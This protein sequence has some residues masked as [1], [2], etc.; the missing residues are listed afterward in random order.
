MPAYD[1]A[2]A[3]AED[4]SAQRLLNLFFIFN[5][6]T[7]PL[8]TDEIVTD[9]DLGYGS[10][11]R[12]SDVRK[13]RR[14]RAKLADQGIQIVEIKPSGASETEESSWRLDREHTFAAGGV[15]TA[16]D[17]QTLAQAIDEYLDGQPTPLARPLRSVRD[18]ALDLV[19]KGTC[20]EHVRTEATT[21]ARS[22]LLDAIW[23]AFSAR[24]KL[25]FA[26]TNARGGT[27]KRTVAIYGLFAHDGATY[28][29]GLDDA[30][31]EV[32]TFRA[33]R[34]E[35]AWRP[36]GTY[37]IPADFDVR[38]HV[39]LPF[40]FGDEHGSAT[41][42]FPA[43]ATLASAR[44]I[45]RGRGTLASMRD[46]SKRDGSLTWTVDV[47]D[48]ASAASFALEHAREGLR[49]TAP[50]ALVD[51]WKNAIRRAVEAHGA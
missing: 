7:R 40:D 47:H 37:R 33:D 44:A 13:F 38:E 36:K 11:R 43:H 4:T 34:I 9:T 51:A 6:S 3:I 39:F 41:F 23:Y 18:K 24:K 32:R 21:D 35:R 25:T 5:T 16:D 46:D 2:Q 17:A 42:A 22:P 8:T 1:E 48:T 26:Y 20:Q 45:T 49:P 31:G 12:E 28:L 27:S 15:I 14:D 19:S 29:T 50:E 10:S 30:S